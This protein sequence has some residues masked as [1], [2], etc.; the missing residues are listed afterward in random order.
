MKPEWASLIRCFGSGVLSES[1]LF[2]GGVR[3][4]G[5]NTLRGGGRG[6]RGASFPTPP[7]FLL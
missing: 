3:G 7:C 6:G 1:F 2:W 5:S 4:G